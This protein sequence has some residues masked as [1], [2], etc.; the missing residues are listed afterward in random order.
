MPGIK[1]SFYSIHIYPTLITI[2]RRRE[3]KMIFSTFE[4]IMKQV[5][6]EGT[7]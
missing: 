3:V 4:Y 2:S 1:Y 6:D 5:K 7:S